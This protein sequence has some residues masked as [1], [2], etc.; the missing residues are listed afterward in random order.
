MS[1]KDNTNEKPKT[2]GTLSL[3][4]TLSVGG[5][6]SRPKSGIAVEVR[7]RRFNTPAEAGDATAQI[8]MSED[9]ELARRAQ[10]LEEA[11]KNAKEEEMRRDEERKQAEQLSQMKADQAEEV[12]RREE[13]E[14]LRLEQDRLAK[15]EAE[16]IAK[17]EAA[18]DAVRKEKA[19]RQE[20]ETKPANDRRPAKSKPAEKRTGRAAYTGGLGQRFRTIP[21]SKR[22]GKKNAGPIIQE[23]REKVIRDVEIPENITVQELASRMS[24][25]V[26]DVVKQLMMMGQ[27]VT[28][29]QTVDQDTAVLLTEEFGH[30]YTT[31]SDAAVEEEV[32]TFEDD[33]KTL[34]GR[35]PVVTVMGHVDHGKTTLLDALRTTDVVGGEAGGITQHIGAYQVK[36]KTGKHV[37]FLDT[38]GHEAFTAMRAR[39]ASVTD[40]VILVVSADDSIMPQTIE[41]INHAKSAE[42][43]IIVAINK[44][45][46][47]DANIDRVKQ[48]LLSHD[49]IPEDFGGDVVC[50]P[51]SAKQRTNLDDLVEMVLLQADMLD[52]KANPERR[53]NG[54]VIESRLDKGRGP[55]ATVI[56]EGGTLKKGDIFV[57]GTVQGRVRMMF[58]DKG[59]VIKEAPP[60]MPVELVGLQS[61]AEAG[62]EFVVVENERKAREIIDYREE[63]RREAIAAS[64]PSAV[65]LLFGRIKEGEDTILNVVLKG[66]VQGSV[67]AIKDALNKLETAESKVKVVHSGVGI[68][69]ETDITLAQTASAAVVGF[70]VRANPQARTL[71]EREKIDIR[72]YSVIY[73]LIDDIKA[74]MA[75]LLSP[76]EMENTLGQ[77]EVRQIFKAGK[78]KI[79]GCMVT[80]G[81]MRR[82]AK[83]RLI[84][85]GKVILDG[86]ID[87]LRRFKDE[88][89]EVAENYECGITLV[90]FDDVH[91]GDII[92]AYE[93]VE[94]EKSVADLEKAAKDKRDQDELNE[95]EM[96]TSPDDE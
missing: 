44:I 7:R 96:A 26:G 89:K 48:D 74:A 15:E 49:L 23:E 87:G 43:P 78:I 41:A 35:P 22:R 6:Q 5:A 32:M 77:A 27:M 33:A 93:I 56:V 36:T 2:S 17:E 59:N 24:E 72:Y 9:S 76:D 81:V 37:T 34:A 1:D 63:K 31:V 66:D 51:I 80:S 25:K 85:D 40:V 13:E 11:K 29:N 75:G 60:A 67:E 73:N 10:A 4:G 94:I 58:D 16:R 52:L 45:D 19:A 38:P 12:K 61:A 46:K 65:D 95:L 69:T 54:I 79:A 20:R 92:E 3:G 47:P 8:D 64:G 50:V 39:G 70:N 84:R 42:V 28:Q 62:D 30:R 57:M 14:V 71:A 53:A 21:N 18:L 91:E 55:V 90:K 82:D 86:Q 68:I 83:V 88:A